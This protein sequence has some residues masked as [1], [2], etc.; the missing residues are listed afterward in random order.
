[1]RWLELRV[2]PPVV[3]GAVA[4]LMWLAAGAL[5]TL[6]FPLPSRRLLAAVLVALGLC[7]GLVAYFQFRAARTTVHPMKPQESS[8][9]VI[10]GIY[11]LTRN[12]MYLGMLLILGAWAAWLANAAALLLLPAFVAYLTRFQI[13]PEER[14][15]EVRFGAAFVAYRRAVRRWL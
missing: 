10:R 6:D 15:L 1:L 2:P 12:P 3:G 14:A 4:L 13:A 11:R 5:P 9:L 7:S 8:A